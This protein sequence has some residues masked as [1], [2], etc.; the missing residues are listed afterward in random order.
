MDLPSKDRPDLIGYENVQRKI[1]D[2]GVL[3]LEQ[4]T[5]QL[6]ANER[7]YVSREQRGDVCEARR[8]GGP[9][10]HL[11]ESSFIFLQVPSVPLEEGRALC[12][13]TADL[14]RSHYVDMTGLILDE[15]KNASLTDA[16]FRSRLKV[17]K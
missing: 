13:G 2:N 6:V 4:S 5:A 10:G 9:R 11:E 16:E 3:S 8:D 17:K 12:E 1:M 7:N 15:H 14:L